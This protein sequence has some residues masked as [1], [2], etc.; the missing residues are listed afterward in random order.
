[1]KLY[2]QYKDGINYT[3]KSSFLVQKQLKDSF[4]A[5]KT[6]YRK[7]HIR[8]RNLTKNRS[9]PKEL[10]KAL[11]SPNLSSNKDN[12]TSLLMKMVH[13]NSRHQKREL[14]SKNSILNQLEISKK[15]YQNRPANLSGT[16][17]KANETYPINLNYETYLSKL[18]KNFTQS[19]YQ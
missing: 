10:S 8:K 17:P 12:Q 15:N 16:Q 6:H 7:S 11:K 14:F 3:K 13:F 18:L 4:K 5:A 19:R 1:M 9:K 2:Q